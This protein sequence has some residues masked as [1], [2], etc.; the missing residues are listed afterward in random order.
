MYSK[1]FVE[2]VGCDKFHELLA[3]SKDY[4]AEAVCTFAYVGGPGEEPVLFQGRTKV[5]GYC[6]LL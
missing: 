1:A 2:S 6:A 5:S 3:V 4:G